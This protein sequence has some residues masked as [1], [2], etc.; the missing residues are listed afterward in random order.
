M[1]VSVLIPEYRGYGRSTG[2][3]SQDAI[4]EDL[5]TFYDLLAA[6]ADVDHSRIVFH[7]VSLGGGAAAQLASQ[8]APRALVLQST[9]TS[10][11]DIA[12]SRFHV[13][14]AIVPEPYDSLEALREYGGPALILHGRRDDL[15]P[16]AHAEALTRTLGA[17]LV[18]YDR[19]GHN[20][21][22]PPGAD[23][24]GEI[25]RF[26]IESGILEQTSPN[27]RS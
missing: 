20:D 24:W 18:A 23:Y 10:V 13:P 14:R 21:L 16:F 7:G 17:R 5:V 1:G 27:P 25:R 2:T 19:S 26:L 9:F 11:A 4:R 8:R 3:P 6:R 12:S 22:P 15:I